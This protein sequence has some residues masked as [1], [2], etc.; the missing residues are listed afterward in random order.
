MPFSILS[1]EYF[2]TIDN[3]PISIKANLIKESNILKAYFNTMKQM[4]IFKASNI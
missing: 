1:N 3:I 4:S 2:I